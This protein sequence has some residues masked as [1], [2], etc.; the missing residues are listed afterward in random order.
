MEVMR[1]MK[2]TKGKEEAGRENE[3]NECKEYEGKTQTREGVEKIKLTIKN[4][5]QKN[6][7]E[8]QNETVMKN[9]KDKKNRRISEEGEHEE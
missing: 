3:V 1:I 8:K 6:G 7:K 5:T 2:M 9:M 4:K